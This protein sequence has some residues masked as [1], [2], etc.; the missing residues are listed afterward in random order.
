MQEI[1]ASYGAGALVEAVTD[2]NF[3]NGMLNSAGLDATAIGKFFGQKVGKRSKPFVG[4]NGVFITEVTAYTPASAIADYS[5]Y[6]DQVLQKVG[7]YTGTY[8]ANM[9]I[10]ENANIK[11]NRAKFF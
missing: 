2:I 5:A 10:R 7:G 8:L 11:D 9:L 4:D 3:A 6:K 1:A